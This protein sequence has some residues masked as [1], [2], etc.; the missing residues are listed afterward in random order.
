MVSLCDILAVVHDNAANVVAALRIMKEKHGV[1][2]HQCAGHTLQ[3]VFNHS[4]KKDPNIN[5]A[6]GAARSLI[7]HFRKSEPIN[8]KL[9]EKQKQWGI[10]E[11]KLIQNVSVRWNSSY[12]M[13]S[14]LLGQRWPVTASLSDPE[15]TQQG[16]HHLDLKSDQV[17]LLQD[18]EKALKPFEQASVLSGQSC[19]TVSA[20]PPLVKGLQKSTQKTF[21]SVPVNSF[22]AATAQEMASRWEGETGF[23]EDGENVCV[24]AT[25]LDPRFCKLKFLSPDDILK[26]QIKIQTLALMYF[27]E[28]CI[29]MD[30]SPLQCCEVA[31]PG[32]SGQIITVSP[33]NVHSI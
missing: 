7:E 9:K 20:L 23:T 18:L 10:S 21:E 32:C 6:L 24:I 15:V 17:T 30:K 33:G 25:A 13:M 26:V 12:Y 29:A 22:Q 31:Q 1:A 16:K 2:P 14:R 27:G 11:H 19:I 28:Q 4:L 3:L 8:S 5:K